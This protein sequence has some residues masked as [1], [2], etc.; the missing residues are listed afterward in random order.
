MCL[1]QTIRL[2]FFSEVWL[3]GYDFEDDDFAF[4]IA[5]RLVDYAA[6]VEPVIRTLA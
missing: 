1:C 4:E 2:T 5:A 3:D 6:A